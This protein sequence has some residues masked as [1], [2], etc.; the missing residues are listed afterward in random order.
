MNSKIQELA[1]EA[2]ARVPHG[3]L[4]VD[5]WIQVYNQEFAKLIVREC[6]TVMYDNAIL[7]KV[8]PDINQTPT[9]YAVAIMEHFGVDP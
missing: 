8:P 4:G 6:V 2:K 9:Q 1:D 5:Q 7:R 3:I